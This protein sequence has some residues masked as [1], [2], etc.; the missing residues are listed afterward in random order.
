MSKQILFD[1]TARQKMRVGIEKLAKTVRVTMGPAGRNVILSKSFGAPSVTK[2]GVS[3]AKE[4]DLDDPFENMGAKLVLEVA[5]KT[6]DVAG[7]GTTTATVLASAIFEQGLKFLASGVNPISLR[8]GI[9]KAVA[10][11][12]AEIES[13]SRKI[14]THAEKA[15]I[16][17]ISANNDP[18]I[19]KLLADAFEKVGDDGVIT[20]EENTGLGTE[21]E[22]VEGM[23]FDKG[24]LSPYFATNAS[25]LIAE[26]EDPYILIHEKKIT[27]ARDLIPLLEKTAQTA[28]PLLIIAEDIEGEA[29]A[30]LVIN[31]LRGI[32]NVCAVKAPGFGERRKAYL[33]DIAA[34]TGGVAITEELGQS[35]ENISIADLGTAKRVRVSKDSTTLVEGGGT[36][37]AIKERC[38]QIRTQIEKTSSDYDREKL[39][40]R[41]AKLSGGVAVVKVGGDT[42]SEMKAAKDLV[43]DA[44]N[45]TR[46]AIQEG[47]VP[48]GGVALLRAADALV[49]TRT[50][51]DEKF[52]VDIV[53]RALE[54]PARQIAE[55]AGEDG[56]VVVEM[57]RE[58]GKNFG[59]DTLNRQYVDMVKAGIIDPAKVVRSALQNAASIAGLL[60]TTDSMVT[61]L[62][63]DRQAI[64]G[65]LS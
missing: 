40:E 6:N 14:K 2:D 11:A 63:D 34:L 39:E 24:Y 41:L 49:D 3:V 56:S 22:L 29:L 47:V 16:A 10:T 55:N 35:L 59:F 51:G 37:K 50:K 27:S 9:E 36:A 60:L 25:K 65:S 30:T 15:S 64:T 53:R 33:G 52:G 19:G 7:D 46:A 32:L 54:Q 18:T 5:K 48:G 21:L 58:K 20:V 62:K 28:R 45:A 1:D 31:R 61:E 57:I 8:N 13:M 26:L 17:T 44:L 12:V 43:E 38:A 23:E 42:E 4:I